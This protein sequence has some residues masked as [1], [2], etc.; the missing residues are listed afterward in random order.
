MITINSAR[1]AFFRGIAVGFEHL[2]PRAVEFSD[3]ACHHDDVSVPACEEAILAHDGGGFA[4]GGPRRASGTCLGVLDTGAAHAECADIM[5]QLATPSGVDAP[6]LVYHQ[7]DNES[8][9]EEP[10]Q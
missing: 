2:A 1:R 3:E 9:W 10:R 4:T 6:P 7:I 5:N 8:Q